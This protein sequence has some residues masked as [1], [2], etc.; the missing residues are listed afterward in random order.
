MSV[1]PT[2]CGPPSPSINHTISSQTQQSAWKDSPLNPPS[3]CT[4]Q[5]TEVQLGS[6]ESE[7]IAI[8]AM[9][10]SPA[11]SQYSGTLHSPTQPRL[12]SIAAELSTVD[13]DHSPTSHTFTQE[14][15]AQTQPS[16]IPSSPSNLNITQSDL[17]AQCSLVMSAPSSPI[18][19]S[20]EHRP[21]EEPTLDQRSPEST[22]P[23]QH[24]APSPTLAQAEQD[25]SALDR[26]SFLPTYCSQT[27]SLRTQ[28]VRTA[29]SAPCS[30]SHSPL[31]PT[32]CSWSQPASPAQLSATPL[33][34]KDK[35]SAELNTE[36]PGSITT[37]PSHENQTLERNLANLNPALDLP[38]ASSP[39]CFP[40]PSP[41]NLEDSSLLPSPA[42]PTSENLDQGTT[43]EEL[44]NQASSTESRELV[45]I[46]TLASPATESSHVSPTHVS[47]PATPSHASEMSP[48]H[49]TASI[50]L[51]QDSPAAATIHMSPTHQASA[52]PLS[53]SPSPATTTQDEQIEMP[54]ATHCPS[55]SIQ[56]SLI[57]GSSPQ[58][59][60]VHSESRCASPILNKADAGTTHLSFSGVSPSHH[61]TSS[62][63]TL[64]STSESVSVDSLTHAQANCS[65]THANRGEVSPMAT[66]TSFHPMSTDTDLVQNPSSPLSIS[67]TCQTHVSPVNNSCAII[68]PSV[69]G[70]NPS[71]HSSPPHD[72]SSPPHSSLCHAHSP[73]QA[74]STHCSLPNAS[75]AHGPVHPNATCASPTHS[76]VETSEHC[77]TPK[78]SPLYTS[79]PCTSS[80]QSPVRSQEPCASLL[81]SPTH[82]SYPRESPAPSP[83]HTGEPCSSPMHSAP[84]SPLQVHP[85][86]VESADCFSHR[87]AS[88]PS[89]LR[90]DDSTVSLRPISPPQT[91][92]TLVT[93][94]QDPIATTSTPHGSPAG[95][96]LPCS[97]DAFSQ[98]ATCD[99]GPVGARSPP[100]SLIHDRPFHAG[101][102]P[103][104]PI[105]ASPVDASP[106]LSSPTHASPVHATAPQT[107]SIHG[108][109]VRESTSPSRSVNASSVHGGSLKS[110]S[111]QASPVHCSFTQSSSVHASPVHECSSPSSPI[112]VGPSHTSCPQSS[113]INVTSANISSPSSSTSQSSSICAG[114]FLART[115]H[116]SPV[117]C[118][119]TPASPT[120]LSPAHCTAAVHSPSTS[121][122]GEVDGDV[123]V[124]EPNSHQEIPLLDQITHSH[125]SPTLSPTHIPFTNTG[126]EASV[127][128]DVSPGPAGLL[129]GQVSPRLEQVSQ[130]QV[131]LGE[132]F[133][134]SSPS[135]NTLR[136]FINC[137]RKI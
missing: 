106:L 32:Q 59:S 60:P 70:S 37:S 68:T 58:A 41:V 19:S 43:S 133:K 89:P 63:P 79:D 94:A 65:S 135:F 54:V 80:R 40:T 90:D 131:P 85:R 50:S 62:S 38:T 100:C 124:D 44:D 86:S 107:D 14:M 16:P 98:A 134:V 125:T 45:N 25:I 31:R 113:S 99:T 9:H 22:I 4:V 6:E 42:L 102:T 88:L 122:S 74:D 126:A 111:T 39:V 5:I 123:S 84:T 52:S 64:V 56:D 108:S 93:E 53:K 136:H 11:H 103:S 26:G 109:P 67:N 77:A 12:S 91:Q 17:G 23:T 92:E 120:V 118:I 97:D 66:P 69:A 112:T 33:C 132:C 34:A 128:C 30:P 15:N 48:A 8:S 2:H 24:A 75:P 47:A 7:A 129:P 83:P 130:L 119:S 1:S 57:H 13:R 20:P 36:A 115:T 114:P 46:L 95:P 55:D 101:S 137:Y 10:G 21:T 96:V 104:T 82:T 27:L 51:A 71:A 116:T 49:S 110:S 87:G 61:Q 73:R 3:S 105:H 29:F 35:S 121:R 78:L 72:H 127:C 81:Q 117:H 76:P 28:A 18:P